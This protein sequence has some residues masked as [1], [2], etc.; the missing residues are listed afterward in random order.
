MTDTERAERDARVDAAR[1]HLT[2]AL[3]A[4]DGNE[5]EYSPAD[6]PP[7]CPHAGRAEV[8][9]TVLRVWLLDGRT[10]TVP[11]GWFP[12]LAE[13]PPEQRNEWRTLGGTA[14]WWPDPDVTAEVEYLLADRPPYSDSD[15]YYAYGRSRVADVKVTDR[16]IGVWLA[17]GRTLTVPL[18]WFPRLAAGTPE[19]RNRWEGY[20]SSWLRWPDLDEDITVGGFLAGGST[21]E[22]VHSLGRWLLARRDG[23]GVT[24]GDISHHHKTL[25]DPEPL[26]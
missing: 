7:R 26:A 16:D 19:E 5:P 12:R 11:V 3:R 21:R 8:S 24:L 20:G 18:W 13:A 1:K 17:D 23:R 22:S 9:D 6:T 4:L 25:P 10:L 14:I 2:D 15:D